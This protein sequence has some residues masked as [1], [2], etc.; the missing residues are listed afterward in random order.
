MDHRPHAALVRRAGGQRARAGVE[1]ARHRTQHPPSCCAGCRGSSTSSR[2]CCRPTGRSSSGW[3]SRSS[4]RSRSPC[5]A[6]C[7]RC[8]LA[9]PVC[10]LAARNLSPNLA[11]FHVTRQV[12]NALRGINE[13]IFALIFVAAVGTRVPSPACWR[14]RFMAPACWASSSPRRSRKSTRDRSRRCAR[15]APALRMVV[16]FGVLPQVIPS[17]IASTLYRFEVNLRAATILGIV[18][19]GGIGFEL[20]QLAEAVPVPG[21]RQLRA[22]HPG[23]W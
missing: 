11:V 17:W 1:C 10:F 12:L 20:M 23:S 5:G 2:A 16:V 7:S 14:S 21:H 19:A 3:S 9:L 8:V 22:R 13:I 6:R 18:G 4:R 15:R